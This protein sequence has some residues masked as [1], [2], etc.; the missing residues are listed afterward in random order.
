MAKS[1][2]TLK[3]EA[4]ELGLENIPEDYQELRSVVAKANEVAEKKEP[5][6]LPEKEIETK[7]KD[8][9][10]REKRWAKL[11]EKYK[12]QNPEKYEIKKERGEFK[13][14]PASFK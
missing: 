3:K 12:I 10:S 5:Q 9:D 8:K 13:E 1:Q 11:L 2:E 14:I 4:E 6:V 7:P